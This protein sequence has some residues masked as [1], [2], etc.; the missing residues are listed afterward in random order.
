[1][2]L[3]A[4]QLNI[5]LSVSLESVPNLLLSF[6]FVSE[7]PIVPFD[8]HFPYYKPWEEFP[9]S[10]KDF[11]GKRLMLPLGYGEIITSILLHLFHKY[12]FPFLPYLARKFAF[13]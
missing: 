3:L 10:I 9:N 13:I 11:T 2:V 6:S 4:S 8:P 12:P 1:M 5:F 7:N